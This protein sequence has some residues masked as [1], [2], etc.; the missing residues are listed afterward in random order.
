[1]KVD[2][3]GKPASLLENDVQFT[4]YGLVVG[5]GLPGLLC[6]PVFAWLRCQAPIIISVLKLGT[7]SFGFLIGGYES[8]FRNCILLQF[9]RHSMALHPP[10]GLPTR[11]QVSQIRQEIYGIPKISDPIQGLPLSLENNDGMTLSPTA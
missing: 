1:M 7:N 10:P 9:F 3:H 2:R 11:P 5:C 8:H 4:I 6:I